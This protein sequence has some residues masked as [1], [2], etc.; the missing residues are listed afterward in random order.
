[1]NISVSLEIKDVL[2]GILDTSNINI[3]VNYIVL[4][5]KNTLFTL[6]IKRFKPKVLLREKM[7]NLIST[8]KKGNPCSLLGTLFSYIPRVHYIQISYLFL[9]IQCSFPVVCN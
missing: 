7:T 4:E 2:F 3:L 5:S 9:V 8:A 1:M 6:G